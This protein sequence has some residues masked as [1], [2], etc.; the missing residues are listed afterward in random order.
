MTAD[1]DFAAANQHIY[2]VSDSKNLVYDGRMNV[3]TGSS[4]LQDLPGFLDINISNLS[5]L[6]GPFRKAIP[7]ISGKN[8]YIRFSGGGLQPRIKMIAAESRSRR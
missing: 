2:P 7:R 4:Q 3:T 1:P 6:K 8:Q 5:I